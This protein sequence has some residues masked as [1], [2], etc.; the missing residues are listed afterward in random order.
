[1]RTAPSRNSGGLGGWDQRVMTRQLSKGPRRGRGLRSHE[2]RITQKSAAT[3]TDVEGEGSV[4]LRS[5]RFTSVS[6]LTPDCKGESGF[7][8]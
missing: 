5:G 7:E 2:D 1:M 3:A 8:L 4:A 6:E